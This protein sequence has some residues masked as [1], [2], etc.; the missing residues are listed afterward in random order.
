MSYSALAL[1][2]MAAAPACVQNNGV[3]PATWAGH[4]ATRFFEELSHEQP[5][6]LV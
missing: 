5:R 1:A 2:P 6:H 4:V 3:G